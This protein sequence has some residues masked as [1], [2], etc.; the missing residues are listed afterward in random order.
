MGF[1]LIN[2]IKI[3]VIYKWRDMKQKPFLNTTNI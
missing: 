2:K 3:Y 1:R